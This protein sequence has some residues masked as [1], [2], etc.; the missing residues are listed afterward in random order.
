MSALVLTIK[1]IMRQPR[2]YQD[3]TLTLQQTIEL[4]ADAAHHIAGVLRMKPSQEVRLFNGKGGEFLGSITEVAKK[5]VSVQLTEF[6]D[7]NVESPLEIHLGQGI[8]RGE[9]MDFTIQ[10][11][12]ELGVKEITPLFSERCGVKLNADRLEKKWQHWQQ[13]AISAAEQS[14]RTVITTVHK[15]LSLQNWLS[16]PTNALKL[17]LHPRASDTIKSLSAPTQGIRFLV[18]PEG[19]LTD[20]EIQQTV[21]ANFNEI[22]L[23]PRILRTETAALTVLSALQLQFGDLA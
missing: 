3:Q 5:R 16:Q 9:K 14:G 21:N 12:V 22:L 17:T 11:S 23:G 4:T 13:I 2:I 1:K 20:D 7:R 8:S 6:I 10:K 18:G 15:P 19:G